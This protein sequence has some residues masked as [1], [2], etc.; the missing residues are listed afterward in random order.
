M[1]DYIIKDNLSDDANDGGG[2]S[3]INKLDTEVTTEI[4]RFINQYPQIKYIRVSVEG[5]LASETK[6]SKESK[7]EIVVESYRPG[8]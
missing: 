4:S 6:F 1:L 2:R 8:T 3:V 7:G 5:E